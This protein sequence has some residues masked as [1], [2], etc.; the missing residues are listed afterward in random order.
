VRGLSSKNYK[1]AHQAMRRIPLF[2]AIIH[3]I[4]D[5]DVES[6]NREL[7]Q[8]QREPRGRSFADFGPLLKPLLRPMFILSSLSVHVHLL[9]AIGKMYEVVKTYLTS[10]DERELVTRY[11]HIAREELV[12]VFQSLKSRLYPVLLKILSD[13][14]LDPDALYL[15]KRDAILEFL[16]IG[17]KDL[18]RDL[19]DGQLGWTPQVNIESNASPEVSE[20]V[21]PKMAKQGFELLDQMFPRA[22]WKSL[23]ELPDLYAYYQTVFSFPKGSDL[24]AVDDAI[25]VIA[26]I[27]EILQQLFFG[28]QNVQWGTATTT[29][30]EVIRLQEEIDKAVARWHFFNEEFFGKNYYPLL[31]EYCREVERTGPASSDSKRREH[32]LLWLKRN[33][34]L[35]HLQIPVMDDVRVK[36]LGFPT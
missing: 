14:Y 5:W 30:G 11:Y 3:V 13:H 22:G 2:N 36:S 34:L 19:P 24:V 6:M 23:G 8:L 12:L 15:E 20:M 18:V 29:S 33:Y 1:N 10:N 31:Q 35:P 16:G 27:S 28:F 25:Q 26:P 4:R 7:T 17:E 9:P 32:Q 21:T